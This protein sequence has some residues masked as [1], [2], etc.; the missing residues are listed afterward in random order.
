[1]PLFIAL[2]LFPIICIANDCSDKFDNKST[3][4]VTGILHETKLKIPP[5]KGFLEGSDFEYIKLM[6]AIS[7][8]SEKNHIGAFVREVE[9]PDLIR[10]DKDLKLKIHGS[11][12]SIKRFDYIDTTPEMLKAEKRA[13]TEQA[14]QFKAS[15][16][17]IKKAMLRHIKTNLEFLDDKE[18]LKLDELDFRQ[19]ILPVHDESTDH[20]SYSTYQVNNL[21]AG[22]VITTQT[23]T[24][25]VVK[26]KLIFLFICGE[27]NDLEETRKISRWWVREV[28]E[29]NAPSIH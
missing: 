13:I 23:M 15:F 1:M 2:F 4:Y 19:K 27:E 12:F 14:E 8:T 20:F 24:M 21:G 5:P 7:N 3:N 25:A 28:F 22:K 16:D 17:D 11:A 18:L 9:V 10:N 26:K 6:K 29:S